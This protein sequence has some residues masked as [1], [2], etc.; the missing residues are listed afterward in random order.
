[1]H[2]TNLKVPY[3]FHL[4]VS[5][6]SLAPADSSPEPE[7]LKSSNQTMGMLNK[8]CLSDSPMSSNQTMAMLNEAY[9]TGQE[10]FNDGHN[11]LDEV[12]GNNTDSIM[13]NK[14]AHKK[15]GPDTKLSCKGD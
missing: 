4:L 5:I 2:S 9:H 3:L 12:S 11:L 13:G 6:Y 8:A 10:A 7:N 15:R 14:T 1:M